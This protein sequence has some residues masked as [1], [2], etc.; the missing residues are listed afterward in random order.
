MLAAGQ[1]GTRG[2]EGVATRIGRD[3]QLEALQDAFRRLSVAGGVFAAEV[4]AWLSGL[5][6]VLI[7]DGLGGT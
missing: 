2:T 4:S 3:A 1:I 6:A 5:A 7:G